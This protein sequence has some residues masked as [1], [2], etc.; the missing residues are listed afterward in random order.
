MRKSRIARKQNS[1][2]VFISAFFISLLVLT[3]SNTPKTLPVTDL[4]ISCFF[5]SIALSLLFFLVSILWG[6]GSISSEENND[7][8][9]NSG[10]MENYD[11]RDG[12]DD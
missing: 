12:G 4:I 8:E 7:D 3:F 5:V 10:Y 9:N 6:D 1:V 2:Y 11:S